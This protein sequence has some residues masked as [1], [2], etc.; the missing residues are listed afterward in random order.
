L[1]NTKITIALIKCRTSY[2]ANP[3]KAGFG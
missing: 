3:L 2:L 1:I